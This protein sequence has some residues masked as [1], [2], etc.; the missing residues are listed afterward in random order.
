MC[1][2]A[3]SS[4]MVCKS[5]MLRDKTNRFGQVIANVHEAGKCPKQPHQKEA[6]LCQMPKGN[7]TK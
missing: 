5:S 3:V 2:S 1:L 6:S 4:E 7:E